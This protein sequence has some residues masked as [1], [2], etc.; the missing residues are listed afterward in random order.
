MLEK[1]SKYVW[2]TGTP[3]WIWLL[4]IF[5][6]FYVAYRAYFKGRNYM[7]ENNFNI[8]TKN[9]GK[10]IPSFPNGWYVAIRS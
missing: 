9:I 2:L 10:T 4:L 6:M 7:C 8:K 1:S 5:L 3:Y